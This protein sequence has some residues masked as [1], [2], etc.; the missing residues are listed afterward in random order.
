MF[1]RISVLTLMVLALLVAGCGGGD[2]E[3]ANSEAAPTPTPTVGSE[4]GEQQ[5]SAG[6]ETFVSTC[7]ACHTLSDAGTNGQIGPNLDTVEPGAEEVLTAIQSGP[8][9]MPANLVEGEQARQVAEYVAANSG[10]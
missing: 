9:Q 1:R 8:G 3:A 4:S 6:R 2:D 5:A 7:G 10:E